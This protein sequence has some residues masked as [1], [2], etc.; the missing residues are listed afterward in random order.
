MISSGPLLISGGEPETFKDVKF[1]TN[2]HPRTAVG[3]LADGSKVFVVVDGRSSK[4]QG[5]TMEE[6]QK[7]MLWLG[8]TDALNLDGGG[9]STMVVRGRIVN[10]PCD[11]KAFDSEGERSVANAIIIK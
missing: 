7:I 11:N 2:R 4:S 8:C 1:N 6:M 5:A 3:I 10:H 9:S